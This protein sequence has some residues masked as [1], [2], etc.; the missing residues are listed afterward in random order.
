MV[1]E[2]LDDGHTGFVRRFFISY[3]FQHPVDAVRFTKKG[4]NI[5]GFRFYRIYG[6]RLRPVLY[7]WRGIRDFEFLDRVQRFKPYPI[8]SILESFKN[9]I[10]N[11][12]SRIA[13]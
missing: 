2:R 5:D 10:D 8:M 12:L 1:H 9:N 7:K 4:Q 3:L 6:I 13:R 11:N